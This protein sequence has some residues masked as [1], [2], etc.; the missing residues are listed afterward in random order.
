MLNRGPKEYLMN[1][2]WGLTPLVLYLVLYLFTENLGNSLAFSL[3]LTIVAELGIKIITKTHRTGVTF[4]ITLA[5]LLITLAVLMIFGKYITINRNIFLIFP[6]IILVC[7]LL[8]VRLSKSYIVLRFFRKQSAFQ[9]A[10]LNEFFE[11]AAIVQYAFTLHIF[12]VLIYKFL[13]D[14]EVLTNDTDPVVYVFVPVAFIIGLLIYENTKIRRMINRLRREEWLPI[15]NG[16]GEVTGKIARSV[17]MQMNNKFLHPVVRVALVCNGKIYLKHRSADDV[18]DPGSLDHPFEKYML[19]NHEINLSVRNS[20]V[21]TLGSELPF[22]FLLKYTYENDYTKRLIFLFVSRISD[23]AEI[24]AN[25]LKGKF[26]TVKQ[27]EDDFGDDSKFSECFQLEYEY[28]KNTVLLIDESLSNETL[29]AN[30][31]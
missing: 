5:S 21:N 9:K 11:L 6:E 20:I 25:M 31:I 27:I 15:V 17:S 26:W 19:F 29:L 18:L 13:K 1:P 22:K 28:L 7:T 23:E 3:L 12:I 30:N 16:R 24:D 14:S 10:Y 4:L 8:V 2:C